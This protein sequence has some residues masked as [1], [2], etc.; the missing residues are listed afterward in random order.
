MGGGVS[1]KAL[2]DAQAEVAAA[3]ADA[4]RAK[5][6]LETA[7]R[8]A[9]TTATRAAEDG[10]LARAAAT[11]LEASLQREKV[12]LEQKE[13]ENQDLA[14]QNNELEEA[15]EIMRRKQQKR[16]M[17]LAAKAFQRRG[18]RG[19]GENSIGGGMSD[20]GIN[21]EISGSQLED[22]SVVSDL[23]SQ[24]TMMVQLTTTM[25]NAARGDPIYD[26]LAAKIDRLQGRLDHEKKEKLQLSETMLAA[27]SEN[28]QLQ[29]QQQV[30][31]SAMGGL[32]SDYPPGPTSIVDLQ[33]SIGTMSQ[34]TPIGF[35]APV[36]GTYGSV[37]SGL[38]HGTT[39][40]ILGG[41]R[42]NSSFGRPVVTSSPSVTLGRTLVTVGRTR[43][44]AVIVD[45]SSSMRLLERSPG[46]VS[47][48]TSGRS[49]WELAREALEL[50][51]PTV[52]ERDDDVSG[53]L[54]SLTNLALFIVPHRK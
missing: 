35:T 49:R 32:P 34:A 17:K 28:I 52:V 47:I 22:G 21:I 41:A 16:V 13:A 7:R 25:E 43:D 27:T 46:A 12:A 11:E 19:V 33:G 8:E 10:A 45:A 39:S 5:S 18:G 3:R 15:L 54:S 30:S 42:P 4:Q 23:S 40:S 1:K 51:V 53:P 44:Y 37:S 6:E 2:E 36:Y 29:Q 31:S 50:I 14:A 24:D 20:S 9:A 48:R 26:S 38:A